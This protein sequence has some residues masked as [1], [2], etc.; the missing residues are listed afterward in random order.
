MN[1]TIEFE[2]KPTLGYGQIA[3]VPQELLE[4][5]RQN[6]RAMDEMLST[7]SVLYSDSPPPKEG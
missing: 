6:S 4:V 3:E 2:A 7:N 1:R 5:M